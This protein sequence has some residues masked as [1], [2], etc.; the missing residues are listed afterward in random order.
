[1]FL[2]FFSFVLYFQAYWLLDKATGLTLTMLG[3]AHTVFMFSGAFAKLRRTTIHFVMFVYLSAWKNLA[4]TGRGFMELD[5]WVSFENLPEKIQVSLT[6]DKNNGYFLKV[7]IH[8]YR[9]SFN[10]S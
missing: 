10:S 7:K 6:S 8:F 9:A 1:L 2:G 4:Q 3:S 5:I